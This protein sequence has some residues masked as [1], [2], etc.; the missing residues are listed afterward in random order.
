[1]DFV[2][3]SSV[4]RQEAQRAQLGSCP[5]RAPFASSPINHGSSLVALSSLPGQGRG[6]VADP[7][8]RWG[9]CGERRDSFRLE[10]VLAESS[11]VSELQRWHRCFVP[12]DSET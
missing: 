9:S 3:R 10:G 12:A 8:E 5:K 11:R 1:M 7:R 2:G 6:E 4:G